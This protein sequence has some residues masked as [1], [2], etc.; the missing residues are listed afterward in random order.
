MVGAF[1]LASAVFSDKCSH[2][3]V[4]ECDSSNGGCEQIC[5]NSVG[6]FECSCDAGFTLDSDNRNCTGNTPSLSKLHALICIK[7]RCG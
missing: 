2:S 6:S 7:Y 3:D 4:N 5:T 1:Y